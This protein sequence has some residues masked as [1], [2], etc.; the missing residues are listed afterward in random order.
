MKEGTNDEIRQAEKDQRHLQVVENLMRSCQKAQLN[1]QVQGGLRQNLLRK[2][3]VEVLDTYCPEWRD[4]YSRLGEPHG[5]TAEA[6]L[7]RFIF[8]VPS[9]AQVRRLLQ[10]GTV[11]PG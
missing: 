5:F 11:I 10:D 9:S 7:E 1:A 6:E 4:A 8:G 3:P 2:I